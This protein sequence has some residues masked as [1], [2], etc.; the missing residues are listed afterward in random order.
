[1]R[2]DGGSFCIVQQI[3]YKYLEIKQTLT[4]KCEALLG[5]I[6]LFERSVKSLTEESVAKD[7]ELCRY[8][9]LLADVEERLR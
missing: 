6:G 5:R 7:D 9:E 8:R 4:E 3:E 2:G 1:M